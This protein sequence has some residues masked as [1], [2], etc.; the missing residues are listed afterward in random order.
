MKFIS[1][2]KKIFLLNILFFSYIQAS[3]LLNKIENII[4]TKDF[5]T[6]KNLIDIKFQEEKLYFKSNN[7]NYLL[8]L[9]TLKDIGLL[10]LSLNSPKNIILEFKTNI[11]PIKSIKIVDDTLKSIGYYYYFTQKI[12]YDGKKKLY[13]KM[14]LQTSNSI[15]P[16]S[17]ILELQNHNSIVTNIIKKENYNWEFII[18][19]SNSKLKDTINIYKESKISLKKPFNAYL[20][21]I[22]DIKSINIK[23]KRLNH[24]HPYIVFYDNGF[25]PVKI[26][27]KDKIIHKLSLKIPKN[28][29]YIKISDLYT[30]NN[31]K[32]GLSIKGE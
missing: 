24:W 32:R 7:L 2:V 4:G 16:L 30:L 12:K 18:D 1:M 13:W 3:I 23:S 29:Y 14:K 5:K 9:Q 21:K 31:I 8:I 15:D 11:D 6:H 10:K 22:N 27:K 26:L 28:S 20:I 17:M 19:N 25:N